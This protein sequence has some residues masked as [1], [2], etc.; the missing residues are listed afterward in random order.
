MQKDLRHRNPEAAAIAL[1][2]PPAAEQI[3]K[4][5]LAKTLAAIP[6]GPGRFQMI[7]LKPNDERRRQD[8]LTLILV[9]RSQSIAAV[10]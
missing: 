3:S 4:T 10:S 8:R 7:L 6:F 9:K 1:S 2:T 5:F